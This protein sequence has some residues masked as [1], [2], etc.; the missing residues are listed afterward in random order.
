MIFVTFSYMKRVQE[1]L[2]QHNPQLESDLSNTSLIYTHEKYK[3][4]QL[5]HQRLWFV[6]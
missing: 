6:V 1:I 4:I 5:Y 2:E 3:T